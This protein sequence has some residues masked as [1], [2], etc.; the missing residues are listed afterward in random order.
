MPRFKTA[1]E[2]DVFGYLVRKRIV[3]KTTTVDV[4]VKKKGIM[5]QHMQG[6]QKYLITN[7]L[8]YRV[9][10]VKVLGT[11]RKESCWRFNV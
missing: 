6:K 5:L 4:D 9:T 8:K 3:F 10:I 2:R 1:F 7:E 11:P